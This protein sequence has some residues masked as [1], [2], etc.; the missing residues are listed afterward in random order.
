V[1]NF[2]V[3]EHSRG[4]DEG[5]LE[6]VA[7]LE[8]ATIEHDG[9]RLKLEWGALTSRPD[10]EVRDLLWWDGG[11]L[12]GFAGRYAFG[13]ETPEVAGMVHP[14]RR[15]HGIGATLLDAMTALC[16]ERGDRRFLLIAPRTSADAR[17]LAA[18]RGGVLDHSEHALELR[19]AVSDGP[20]DAAITLRPATSADLPEVQRIVAEAF[21]HP[22]FPLDLEAPD[23]PTLVAERDGQVLGTLRVHRSREGWGVYGFAVEPAHQG[24]GIGRDLLRRVCHQARAAGVERVH[25]EVSV[26]NDRALGLYTSLGFVHEATEDYYALAT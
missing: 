24:K 4:L 14:S 2:H 5:K 15:R 1:V 13:S 7:R 18:V 21:G 9:G 3:L 6:S 26:E 19:G 12:V 23:E 22:F 8:A 11:E 10:D 25:L 16:R 17:R 20:V